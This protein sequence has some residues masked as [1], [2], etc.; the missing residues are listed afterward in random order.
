M[1]AVFCAAL[2]AASCESIFEQETDCSTKF[3]FEFRKHRQAL[4]SV[5]GKAADVFDSEVRT[6]HLFVFDAVT[7]EPV[8]EQFATTDRLR[9][10][11]ELKLGSGTQRSLLP[12]DLAP[13]RYR[14]VA[15]CGLDE[16]DGNN[17]FE[18]SGP[19]SRAG[20][21]YDACRIR[22]NAARQPV[23]DD[24]YEAVYHGCVADVTVSGTGQVVPV[25]L[26]KD[27]NEIAVWIQ[28]TSATFAEGD[29]EVVYTDANGTMRF[30]D[31]SPAGGDRLEYRPHTTSTLTTS[32]EYNGEMIEA[33]ALVA[34]LSTARLM[35]AGRDDARLEVRDRDGATLFSIPFIRY[36]LEM[37]TF[38][39]DEQYYLDCEDT[40]NCSFY[41]FAGDG[42]SWMPSMIIINNW[43][44]VPDQSGSIGAE[45]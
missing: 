24:K 16:N 37:Q 15:W 12:V 25:E 33:G 11:A 28:H 5:N 31:N 36:L 40:Y 43:V 39:S 42:G 6:V 19:G 20:F 44:K 10:E 41:L 22:L 38:T 35:A 30:D 3:R 21:G 18:L 8:V 23:N 9:T 1:S 7:G 14:I 32:M 26:T 2:L 45:D 17:A 27:T 4:Q 29:Y 34:H 13:G